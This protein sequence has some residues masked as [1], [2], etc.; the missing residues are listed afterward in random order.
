MELPDWEDAYTRL[1]ETNE[2]HIE[3][4]ELGDRVMSMFIRRLE[5]QAE[6]INRLRTLLHERWNPTC[7]DKDDPWRDALWSEE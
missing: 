3:A 6:E 5:Q 7:F 4:I 2:H 1:F